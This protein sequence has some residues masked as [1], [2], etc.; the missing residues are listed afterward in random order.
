MHHA[1]GSGPRGFPLLSN[2]FPN[3][4][5]ISSIGQIPDPLAQTMDG[6]DMS[7]TNTPFL[8]QQIN[9]VD[10][11]EWPDSPPIKLS[12]KNAAPIRD[13]TVDAVEMERIELPKTPI[14]NVEPEL[15][16]ADS[17]TPLS[18]SFIDQCVQEI[19]MIIESTPPLTTSQPN[20]TVAVETAH[21]DLVRPPLG[22]PLP[23]NNMPPLFESEHPLIPEGQFVD[24]AL[25]Y[26]QPHLFHKNVDNPQPLILNP[27]AR[28]PTFPVNNAPPFVEQL[29]PAIA[30]L[31]PGFPFPAVTS[32]IVTPAPRPAQPTP[33]RAALLQSP[34][35][36]DFGRHVPLH[37][38][39]S[40]QQTSKAKSPSRFCHVCVRPASRFGFLICAN[41]SAG[42]CRKVVCKR[43]FLEFNWDWHAAANDPFWTCSHC[44]GT[45]PARASC[46]TYNK[47]NKKRNPR[48]SSGA[49]NKRRRNT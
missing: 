30:P 10:D 25:Y 24:A 2:A 18:P 7:N 39:D 41:T 36:A 43:C 47:S 8:S 1:S 31:T 32:P 15:E 13:E 16:G 33:D 3:V 40:G 46:F 22:A 21:F 14:S 49:Q 12:P 44:A 26:P 9:P 45:C 34:L 23:D 20:A 27:I 5:D 35:A 17:D 38:G 37:V 19:D 48:R 29:A 11:Y 42:A 6:I 28:N 4:F